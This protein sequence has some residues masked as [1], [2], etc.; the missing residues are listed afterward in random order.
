MVIFTAYRSKKHGVR[1]LRTAKIEAT[2]NVFTLNLDDMLWC[3]SLLFNDQSSNLRG[4]WN[5]TFIEEAI[6]SKSWQADIFAFFWAA[7]LWLTGGNFLGRNLPMKSFLDKPQVSF[8]RYC[9]ILHTIWVIDKWKTPLK[10]KIFNEYLTKEQFMWNQV[11]RKK[12][13]LST[14]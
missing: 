7:K 14:S 8:Y 2:L 6:K 4:I 11:S 13:S 1:C 3:M 10:I 12:F 5:E 9:K